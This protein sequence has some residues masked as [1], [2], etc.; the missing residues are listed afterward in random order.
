MEIPFIHELFFIIVVRCKV[1]VYLHYV[2]EVFGHYR[3][4]HIFLVIYY[5][6]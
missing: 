3:D 6:V 2:F 1:D 4:S 5:D